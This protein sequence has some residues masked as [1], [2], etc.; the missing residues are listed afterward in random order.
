MRER[1]EKG[2]EINVRGERRKK[3]KTDMFTSK[4]KRENGYLKNGA[5]SIPFHSLVDALI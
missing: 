5:I 4:Y 2:E 3:G 1:E